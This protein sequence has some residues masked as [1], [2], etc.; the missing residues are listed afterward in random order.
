MT[1]G[2]FILTTKTIRIV[3]KAFKMGRLIRRRKPT[4]INA[5]MKISELISAITKMT[6]SNLA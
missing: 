1:T 3:S 6:R 4:R 5:P 2:R